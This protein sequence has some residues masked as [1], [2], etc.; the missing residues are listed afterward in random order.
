MAIQIRVARIGV[1]SSSPATV[2]SSG[3]QEGDLVLLHLRSSNS[4]L[5]SVP[6][7]FTKLTESIDSSNTLRIVWKVAG[8]SEPSDYT[9]T[10]GGGTLQMG[11]L[12]LYSDAGY[13]LVHDAGASQNNGTFTGT[14]ICPSIT[15]TRNDALL[16]AFLSFSAAI[17]MSAGS[18]MTQQYD[19][20]GSSTL[21]CLTESFPTPGATGTRTPT[22]TGVNSSRTALIAYAE[23]LSG[24]FIVLGDVT[25]SA[26]G[27]VAVKGEAD[28]TLGAITSS[29]AGLLPPDAPTDF[30]AVAISGSRIDLSW[31][32]DAEMIDGFSIER[33]P[34]GTTG[35]TVIN[36]LGAAD[37]SYSDTG[38]TQNTQF[39]YRLRAFRN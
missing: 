37:R 22:G 20:A 9:T 11:L 8:G 30:D 21:A 7:G 39:F 34:N 26:T 2:S 38:L 27:T 14:Y 29:A 28:I 15:T 19:L 18:G 16:I 25:L 17:N 12:A 1:A 3:V 32:S 10:N 24:G 35:W 36:T 23:D 31:E 4:N 13:P 33:S 5:P 6:S